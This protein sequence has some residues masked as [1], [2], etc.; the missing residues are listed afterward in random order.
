MK[1]LLG[2]HIFI[3]M[4]LSWPKNGIY[5]VLRRINRETDSQYISDVQ[6]SPYYTDKG[7]DRKFDWTRR[8]W[9][10]KIARRYNKS[11]LLN[12]DG[13]LS[14][15]YGKTTLIDEDYSSMISDI[16]FNELFRVVKG[17]GRDDLFQN[18]LD[19]FS[20]KAGFSGLLPNKFYRKTNKAGYILQDVC[21]DTKGYIGQHLKEVFGVDVYVADRIWCDKRFVGEKYCGHNYD[22]NYQKSCDFDRNAVFHQVTSSGSD[23]S[24]I[25][26]EEDKLNSPILMWLFKDRVVYKK[27]QGKSEF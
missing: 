12:N 2:K 17:D 18:D 9:F 5:R 19:T 25:S 7:G 6:R 26:A 10:Q 4:D 8:K 1:D 3:T 27:E 20:K 23:R 14:D 13:S 15:Y 16:D 21:I 11:R 22:Y 24:V